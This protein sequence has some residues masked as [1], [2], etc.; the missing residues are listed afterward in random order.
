MSQQLQ[1]DN[2]YRITLQLHHAERAGLFS[3]LGSH[4]VVHKICM[5]QL[6]GHNAG[7]FR[8]GK[9]VTEIV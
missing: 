9:G 1:R 5:A 6:V 4:R 2:R 8:I 7:Q 3:A